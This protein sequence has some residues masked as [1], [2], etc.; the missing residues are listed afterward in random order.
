MPEIACIACVFCV[1]FA[2]YVPVF[3]RR[4]STLTFVCFDVGY[5]VVKFTRALDAGGHRPPRPPGDWS[6]LVEQAEQNVGIAFIPSLD[7]DLEEKRTN[8]IR[9]SNTKQ[10]QQ[11]K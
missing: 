4:V 8:S 2:A 10:Q 6:V 1:S 5:H 11:Y 9:I 7:F 3:G